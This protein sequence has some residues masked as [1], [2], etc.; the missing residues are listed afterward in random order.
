MK[1]LLELLGRRAGR[2]VTAEELEG[3]VGSVGCAMNFLGKDGT[4]VVTVPDYGKALGEE[5]VEEREWGGEE[6]K[7]TP[8]EI[9]VG[10][11]LSEQLK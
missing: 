7:F 8:G 9:Q 3:S 2:K 5:R 1:R 4:A 6:T 11:V 10:N